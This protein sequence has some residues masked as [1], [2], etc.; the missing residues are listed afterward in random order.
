[1][2]NGTDDSA[3][4]GAL[5]QPVVSEGI[6]HADLAQWT[7]FA[8]DQFGGIWFQDSR[9]GLRG[10]RTGIQYTRLVPSSSAGMT[11]QHA[12][13]I[14]TL[15]DGIDD[16]RGAAQLEDIHGVPSLAITNRTLRRI[17]TSANLL[18]MLTLGYATIEDRI[19]EMGAA[20]PA[21]PLALPVPWTQ[22][23]PPSPDAAAGRE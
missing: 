12:A 18:E 5:P 9:T 15:F 3:G 14:M 1:V 8:A 4:P 21:C 20:K 13:A 23:R 19:H 11:G 7:R 22:R 10:N 16:L 6:H 17:A 2:D